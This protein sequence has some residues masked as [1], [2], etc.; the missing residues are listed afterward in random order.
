MKIVLL[1]NYGGRIPRILMP[2]IAGKD[3][4]WR[5]GKIIDKIEAMAVPAENTT[6]DTAKVVRYTA[7]EK[8]KTYLFRDDNVTVSIVDV[9]IGRPWTIIQYDGAEIVQYLDYKVVDEAINYCI[10]P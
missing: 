3:I 7:D 6:S 9:D 10:L 1:S 4:A 8:T 5:W 2:D